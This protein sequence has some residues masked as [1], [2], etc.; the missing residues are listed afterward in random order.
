MGKG[1]EPRLTA[2]SI[3]GSETS[4][5]LRICFSVAVRRASIDAREIDMVSTER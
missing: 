2:A 4:T 5:M 3:S 1:V